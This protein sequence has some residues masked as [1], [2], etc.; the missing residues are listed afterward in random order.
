MTESEGTPGR[1]AGGR[2]RHAS[3][4]TGVQSV[5][6]SL[7]VLEVLT[8]SKKAMQLK[9]IAKS[10]GIAPS[11]AHR[12]LA[13]FARA[14][15]VHQDPATGLYDLGS[16][17]LRMGLAAL[18]RIDAVEMAGEALKELVSRTETFGVASVWGERGPTV[19]RW[20]RTSN[21]AVSSLSL[22]TIF[23][24]L[25]SSTGC[26]F[27][28]YLPEPLTR[29][30]VEAELSRPLPSGERLTR[31]DVARMIEET[32]RRRYSVMTGHYLANHRGIAAPVL[33]SRG[34]AIVVLSLVSH[35]AGEGEP[36]LDRM[37]RALDEVAR[38]L[39][40]KLGSPL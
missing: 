4:R 38:D 30:F 7:K 5:D 6:Q 3:E 26:V 9:D 25:S 36:E 22:G 33:D 24:V 28:S 15:L 40:A 20:V 2:R 21:I 34:E 12:Y 31:A 23:T 14:E 32:R 19:V 8:A 29:P 13:S 35:V 39:S 16:M 11:Q 18:N 10:T 27:L 17:A 37:V 1:R